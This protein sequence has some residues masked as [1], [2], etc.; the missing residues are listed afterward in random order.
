MGFGLPAAIGAKMA[1]PERQV[2]IFCGDGGFQMTMQ[3]LGT[4]MQYGTAVKI[5]ILNNDY[6]G[7]VRQWQ[8]MF[9]DN[10]FSQTPMVNP[11]FIAIAR[12]YGI[13]AENVGRRDELEPAIRRMMECPG[14]YLLNVRVD[15]RD[16]VFPMTPGG[17]A[18]DYILLDE[19]TVYADKDNQ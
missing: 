12:A 16:M 9:Y 14:P 11:D 6:L 13:E 18:V 4:I 7:N 8:A 10:R 19:H 17:E 1:A 5:I 15:E 2:C 3:E